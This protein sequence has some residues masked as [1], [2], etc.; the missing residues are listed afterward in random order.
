MSPPVS[1]AR[2]AQFRLSDIHRIYLSHSPAYTQPPPDLDS[3]PSWYGVTRASMRLLANWAHI[4]AGQPN[5]ILYSYLH[6][7][8]VRDPFIS[9]DIST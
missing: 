4:L 8:F 3:D 1:V 2:N 9:P 5:N 7:N 6:T